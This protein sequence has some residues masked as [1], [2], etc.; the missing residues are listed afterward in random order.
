MSRKIMLKTAGNFNKCLI[1]DFRDSQNQSYKKMKASYIVLTSNLMLKTK[2]ENIIC[3]SFKSEK[4][5]IT[6]PL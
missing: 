4:G 5:K 2:T 1:Y 3:K 6:P